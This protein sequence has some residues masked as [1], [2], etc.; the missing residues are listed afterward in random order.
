MLSFYLGQLNEI[1]RSTLWSLQV[2]NY[3]LFETP[4]AVFY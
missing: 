3:L 1:P 2:L 4:Q